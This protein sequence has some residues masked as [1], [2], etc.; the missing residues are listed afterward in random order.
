MPRLLDLLAYLALP[1][2]AD[3]WVLLDIKRDDDAHELM[4]QVAAT[5]AC[6]KPCPTKPWHERIVLGPWDASY[7]EVCKQ[8]LPGFPMAYI[9]WSV[10]EANKI[11]RAPGEDKINFNLLL[12]SLLGPGGGT[13]MRAARQA[14]RHL[15]VWTVNQEIWMEWCIR[16]G[17]DGVITDDPKLY[18]EVCER[19]ES[20]AGAERRS[21]TQIGREVV[22]KVVMAVI[23]PFVWM[24]TRPSPL[25]RNALK[26]LQGE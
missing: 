4:S 9:G 20:G 8:Y 3:I 6:V 1:E 7:I 22:I 11:L 26:R 25:V 2:N 10:P 21:I 17:V 24:Q 14:G 15:F 5:I 18:R 23:M 19:W 12:F 13:F 16:K